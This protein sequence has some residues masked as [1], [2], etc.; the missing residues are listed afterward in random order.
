MQPQV[1]CGLSSLFHARTQPNV[2]GMPR[3]FES[4]SGRAPGH[5]DARLFAPATQRNRQ[6]IL[7][8]L[9]RV[10]PGD[11]LVLEIASGSGEHARWFAQH[12]RPLRWQPSDPDP[13]MRQSI[14]AHASDADCPTLLAPLDIDVTH[15]S[16]DVD[17]ADAV[18]CINL[19][20]IAPWRAAE[21]LMAGAARLLPKDGVL[22]LYGPYKREGGHTAPSNAVFDEGLRAQNPDWGVRDLEA[23]AELA[24]QQ[25]FTLRE[26]VK[27]PANN[28]S[29]V[30]ARN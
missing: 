12:L 10:L 13:L 11:G 5:L 30:F 15:E 2:P 25:G 26:I 8:V 17:A 7:E 1:Y 4:A 27:M 19:L 28:L 22:Y 20:H 24:E 21:G 14:A 6:A 3:A 29:L 23:V 16:W 18:V 9:D